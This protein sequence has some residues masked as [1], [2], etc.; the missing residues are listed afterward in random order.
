MAFA[1]NQVIAPDETNQEA[2][3]YV[4]DRV[5]DDVGVSDE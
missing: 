4:H 5:T 1:S 2:D 3:V